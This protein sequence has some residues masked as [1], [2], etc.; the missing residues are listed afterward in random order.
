MLANPL[1][2]LQ[3]K[4]EK[5]NSGRIKYSGMW[6]CVIQWVVPNTSK[7]CRAFILTIKQHTTSSTVQT[8]RT[9]ALQSFKMS[10][11]ARPMTQH[12]SYKY[13]TLEQ[14]QCENLK[15]YRWKDFMLEWNK[16]KWT[17]INLHDPQGTYMQPSRTSIILSIP[18][19]LQQLKVLTPAQ[20]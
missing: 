8:Q 3:L 11:T 12:H 1:L 13:L 19:P 16:Q 15:S 7:D 10:G 6:H 14:H 9:K 5:Q 4:D 17:N 20:Q 2:K 18:I